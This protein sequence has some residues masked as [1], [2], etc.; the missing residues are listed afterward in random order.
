MGLVYK[1]LFTDMARTVPVGKISKEATKLLNTTQEALEK[2]IASLSLNDTLYT[3]GEA[4]EKVAKVN[5]CSIIRELTG[6]GVGHEIHED[7]HVFNFRDKESKKTKIV[8]GMVIAI[9]PML[10]LGKSDIVLGD[11][12][13]TYETEDCSLAAQFENTV[14]IG[15]D[16]KVEILTPTKWR[17]R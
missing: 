11:D 2:A 7:P 9:E 17:F 4:V 8:K 14:A 1:N 3:I 13:W 10:A 5:D 6:H 15:Y 16:G 12:G